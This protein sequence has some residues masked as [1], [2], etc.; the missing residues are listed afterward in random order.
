MALPDLS[1]KLTYEDYVLL[2]EDGQRHEILEGAHYVTPAPTTRHQ[3]LSSRLHSLLGPWVLE[4]DLGVL[5]AAPV[6]VLL[7][8]LDVAQPDLLFISN[9]RA[10]ILTAK[11]VQG[12][13][14]LVI[15]ILSESTRRRDEG[16]KLER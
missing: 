8:E 12:S 11:N 5:L 4:R 1:R 16:I 15:E 13:P 14:D 2:P 6:D 7:S 3:V 10:G 9:E